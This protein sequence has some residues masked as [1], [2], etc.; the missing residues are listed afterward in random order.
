MGFPSVT[1]DSFLGGKL[2]LKQPAVGYRAGP[3][4]VLLAASVP[5]Q[6]S[7]SVLELGC[8]VGAALLCLNARVP[9]LQLTGVEIQPDY[10]ELARENAQGAVTVVTA[11]LD[12]LPLA[13]RDVQYHH[14]LANPPYYL[15]KRRKKSGDRGRETAFTEE[16][17]LARWI[18]IAAKRLRPKGVFSLIQDIERLPE[19]LA[20]ALPVLG[21]LEVLPVCAREGRRPQRFLLR[22]RKGG[23]AEFM[24]HAPLIL[25][26]GAAH[27]TDQDSYRPEV[28]RILR[29]GAALEFPPR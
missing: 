6:S 18:E 15:E 25:H 13:I 8:G 23:R 3:D 14:V 10:A 29:D 2:T 11:D 28:K 12:D 16:T 24:M 9:G 7:E 19:V 4:A 22:A 5:A 27:T 21:S 26:Q 17:P 1:N 20:A